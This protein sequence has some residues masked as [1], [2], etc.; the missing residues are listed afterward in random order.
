MSCR[1]EATLVSLDAINAFGSVHWHQALQ[2][3][4]ASAPKLAAPLACLWS[5]GQVDVFTAQESSNWAHFA[6]P[7]SLIQG[8]VEAYLVFV[9]SDVH[10]ARPSIP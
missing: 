2:I 3:L 6:I 8:H 7:G 10:R 5:S 4:L 1:P 9:P